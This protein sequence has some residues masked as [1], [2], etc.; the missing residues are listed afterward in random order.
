MATVGLPEEGAAA[1]DVEQQQQ[2][3]QQHEHKDPLMTTQTFR[4]QGHFK[5][6]SHNVLVC[7]DS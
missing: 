3:Q 5:A 6:E 4:L 1:R 2:Q 7:V